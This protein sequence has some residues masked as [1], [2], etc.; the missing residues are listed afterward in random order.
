MDWD[1]ISYVMS[2]KLRFKILVLLK[3][4]QKTPS[5]LKS[6]IGTHFSNI[7]KTLKELE[8]YELIKCLTPDRKKM[9]FYSLTEKGNNIIN[10]INKMTENKKNYD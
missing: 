7:S 10:E 2:G 6:D 5:D 4:S 9:K 1:D 3:N 8:N